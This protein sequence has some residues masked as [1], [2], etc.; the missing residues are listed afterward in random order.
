MRLILT[1]SQNRGELD[2]GR[3]MERVAFV[4]EG[5]IAERAIELG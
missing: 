1:I 2:L 5:M 3:G 4:V